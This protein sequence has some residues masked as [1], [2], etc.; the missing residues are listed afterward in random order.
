MRPPAVEERLPGYAPFPSKRGLAAEPVRPC[1]NRRLP[2]PHVPSNPQ[3]R[4]PSTEVTP[5]RE[6][7]NGNTEVRAHVVRSQK[8]IQLNVRSHVELGQLRRPDLASRADPAHVPRQFD[9]VPREEALPR[10]A[11]VDSPSPGHTLAGFPAGYLRDS[12]RHARWRDTRLSLT[13]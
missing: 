2:V 7:P 8:P 9:R 1:R 4:R 10:S 12:R 6:R 5:V 11:I 3:E 13:P